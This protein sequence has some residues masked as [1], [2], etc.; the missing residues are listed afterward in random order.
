[1]NKPRDGEVAFIQYLSQRLGVAQ[2][3]RQD[4]PAEPKPEQRAARAALRRG[5]GKPAAS[6]AAMYPYVEPWLGAD[7]S[8]WQVENYYT[9]AALM[10]WHPLNWPDDDIPQ[11][12]SNLGASLLRLAQAERARHGEAPA[13]L[14][15]RLMAMLSATHADLP[16]HLRHAIALLKAREVPV[17]W[18]QLLADLRAWDWELREVQRRWARAFWAATPLASGQEESEKEPEKSEKEDDAHVG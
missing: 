16:E 9:V 2:A 11:Q 4:K 7:A 18:V 14:E 15:R 10:A 1:M 8:P 17:N 6:V 5:L 12:P 3:G 13:G